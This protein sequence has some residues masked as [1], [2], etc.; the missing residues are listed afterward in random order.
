MK[1]TSTKFLPFSS[2]NRC[3]TREVPLRIH[4]TRC[5]Q[6]STTTI[7]EILNKF[8]NESLSHHDTAAQ[9]EY[10]FKLIE[11]RKASDVESKDDILSIGNYAKIDLTRQSRAGFPEDA[12]HL[13]EIMR[14]MHAKQL[15]KVTTDE[16]Q[17]VNEN[18]N[19]KITAKVNLKEEV[20]IATRVS[21]DQFA[22]IEE[23]MG[24]EVVR[25]RP[26]SRIAHTIVSVAVLCAGTSDFAVAEEAA[27]L[28]ELSG[29]LRV[30]D[31]GVA[32]LH[33]LLS[34]LETINTADVVIV[35]AV[36]TSIGYGVAFQ[37]I[38]AMLTMLNSCAPG[39]SVVNIDN[40]FGAAVSAYKI[41]KLK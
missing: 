1:R 17:K 38:S 21:P 35:C 30:Y 13:A 25:Y 4:V 12:G 19:D 37:G 10:H 22:R 41:L 18:D 26:H 14:S 28:L 24:D 11:N 32:G 8:K 39:V 16:I 15:A 34:N 33:R 20:V 9:L 5:R 3:F 27:V 23:L 29:V 2:Y 40:G 36:P 31:V 6:F 7:E